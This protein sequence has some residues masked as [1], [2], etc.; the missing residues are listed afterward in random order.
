MDARA[1]IRGI[2]CGLCVLVII[3]PA[4]AQSNPPAPWVNITSP[5]ANSSPITAGSQM[6]VLANVEAPEE[7]TVVA[8]CVRIFHLDSEGDPIYQLFAQTYPPPTAPP[9]VFFAN[10]NAPTILTDG[11]IP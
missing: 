10:F 8:I 7:T 2:L 1:S 4:V 6:T 11:V 5:G 3:R 9:T